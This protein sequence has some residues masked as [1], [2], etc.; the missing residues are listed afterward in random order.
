MSDPYLLGIAC[1]GDCRQDG[2]PKCGYVLKI[3]DPVE[4]RAVERSPYVR[5][6]QYKWLPATVTHVD[7]N[8]IGV[9][10]SDG[11]R[12]AIPRSGGTQWRTK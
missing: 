5:G 3:G 11:G 10:F 6:V 7:D 4:V 8:Q 2:C 9:A 12:L 1:D